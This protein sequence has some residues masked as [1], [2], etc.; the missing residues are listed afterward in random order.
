M[1]LTVVGCSGSA[2]GAASPASCYLVEAD[3]ADGRTWRVALDLGSGALGPL[4]RYA[5]PRSLDAILISHSH[6]D[7]CADLAVMDVYLRYH[8][9][10]E[11]S[12]PVHGPFGLGGR[13]AELRGVAETT[14]SLP[15]TAWQPGAPLTVGP[16][17]V[18]CAA[19]EHP[20]PAYAMRLTGPSES[21]GEAT[22][23]YS[24]DTDVCDGLAE[25]ALGADLFLCE[26][27]FLEEEDGPRGLHLTGARAGAVAQEAG[28]G[29]LLLT[30]VPPWTDPNAI[31]AE[32]AEQFTGPLQA[33]HPGLRRSL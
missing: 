12:V 29:R 11:A 19:V 20:V 30:H 1:R 5:G 16:L 3:D 18:T 10:G 26:A 28:A 8:P 23:V 6:A 22:L 7:H 27:S 21:G 32:A 25:L 33:A 4:Q 31:V 17:T 9:D 14:A 2:P 15:V 13:I 24:G